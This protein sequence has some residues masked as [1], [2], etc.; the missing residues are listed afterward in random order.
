M[1]EPTGIPSTPAP[2]PEA[3]KKNNTPIIIAAV[4]IVLCCC[5]AV[6]AGAG[7]Y[8]WNNGDALLGTGWIAN[9]L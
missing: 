8:L 7:W 3:P 2:A 4:V 5:C 1:N 9:L 6:V